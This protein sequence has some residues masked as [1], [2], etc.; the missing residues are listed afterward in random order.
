MIRI[1]SMLQA[2]DVKS[3]ERQNEH[4]EHDDRQDG[5]WPERVIE[6]LRRIFVPEPQ[7]VPVPVPVVV[8]PGSPVRRRV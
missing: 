6:V 3:R 1:I 8:R 2:G 5:S 4:D 7:P